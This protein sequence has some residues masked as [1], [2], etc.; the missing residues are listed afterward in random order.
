VNGWLSKFRRKYFFGEEVIKKNKQILTNMGTRVLVI[1]GASSKRNG[2]LNDVLEALHGKE[3]VVF[4]RIKENP[5]LS[6]VESVRQEFQN[7]NPDFILAIG[8]G[9]AM[10]CAKAIAVLLENQSLVVSD[11]F[12]PLRYSKAKPVV[13]VS[14]TSG[15][16]SKVTP[17]SVLV[18]DGRKKGFAHEAVVPKVAFIDYRYSL[19]L[20]HDVTLSTGL[21]ALSHAVESFLSLKSD[22]LT[23]QISLQALKLAKENLP[24]VLQSPNELE[25]RKNMA[26]ASVMAGMVISHTGTTISHAMGNPLTTEK[27]LKHGVAASLSLPFCLELYES[28]KTETIKRIFG[29]DLLSYF[30]ALGVRLNFTP[31]EVEIERWAEEMG[32]D[33]HLKNTPGRFDKE[34][35]AEAYRKLFEHFTV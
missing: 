31:T 16:G 15:S 19:T 1:T 5:D 12:N 27:G 22:P 30:K 25:F 28:S 8:G 14:T 17:Y 34:K 7:Y 21:D 13:C 18:V 3:V 24:R 23:E 10:D 33:F 4:N 2:A 11:L 26:V 6:L 32:K 35:I 29:G 20:D 9:S